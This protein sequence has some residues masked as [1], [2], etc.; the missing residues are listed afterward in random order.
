MANRRVCAAVAGAAVFLYAGA[1]TAQTSSAAL[2]RP[3]PRTADG[4]PDLSAV[5]QAM[6]TAH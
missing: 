2:G 5:W 1:A 3:L 4:K 6:T